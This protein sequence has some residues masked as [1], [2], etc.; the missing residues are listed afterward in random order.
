MLHIFL[1]SLILQIGNSQRPD[2]FE[3]KIIYDV[4]YTDINPGI[5]EKYLNENMGEYME[6]YISYDGFV[7]EYYSEEKL[8]HRTWFDAEK[9]TISSKFEAEDT[10]YWYNASDFH[11]NSTL[12]V[13]PEEYIIK[14]Y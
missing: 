9:N 8:I 5:D 6:K 14:K 11:F 4:T 7:E 10:L 13:F 2:Y 3:G 1:I 12:E